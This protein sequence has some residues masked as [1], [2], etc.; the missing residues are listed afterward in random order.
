MSNFDPT[1]LLDTST[2]EQLDTRLTPV[3]EGEWTAQIK[4]ATFRSFATKD[5]GTFIKCNIVWSIQDPEVSKVTNRDENYVYQNFPVDTKG[6]GSELALDFSKG[7]NVRLGAVRAAIGQNKPGKKW[8]PRMMIGQMAKVS[9]KQD[10][11]PNDPE[12]VYA[13]VKSV[14]SL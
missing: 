6:D 2:D 14:G 13:N 9:V 3:P 8:S 7:K 1:Q 4:D 12:S 10:P 5:G 11:N